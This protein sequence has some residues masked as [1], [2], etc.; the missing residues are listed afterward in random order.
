VGDVA[1]PRRPT[2][3]DGGLL[4]LADLPAPGTKRWVIRRKAVV[5]AAIRGGL[6]TLEEACNRYALT[7]D[8][9]LDWQYS[10]DHHGLAG[11][12]ISRIQKHP[13]RGRP[14][15]SGTPAG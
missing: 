8:E 14:S 4:T 10:I 3:P 11:L 2:R 15:C 6:L 12:R 13:R 5:V 1:D 7:V 9:L